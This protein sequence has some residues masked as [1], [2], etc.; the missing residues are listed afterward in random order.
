MKIT[1]EQTDVKASKVSEHY[2]MCHEYCKQHLQ[3]T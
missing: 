1:L 3:L 2:R